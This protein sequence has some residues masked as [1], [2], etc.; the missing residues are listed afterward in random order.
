MTQTSTRRVASIDAIRALT[1][2]LMLFVNDI[3]G[4]KGVPHWLFHAAADEDM[5]G[6]SDT[7]F[8]AFLFCVGMSVPFAI[9]NRLRRGASQWSVLS[10]IL[11]RSFALVV[12]GLFTLNCEEGA[13]HIPYLTYSLLM[14]AGFFLIWTRYEDTPLAHRTA[15]VTALKAA[16]ALLLLGM[17]VWCD[18]QGKPFV[19]GWWGILGLIG[20]SYL[21][22]ALA[23]LLCRRTMKWVLVAAVLGI[24]LCVLNSSSLVPQSWFSRCLLLPFVPG[25][26]S[27]HAFCLSGL[28]ASMLMRHYKARGQHSRLILLFLGIGAVMLAAGWAAHHWWIVSKIQGTPTWLFFCLA[29]FFPLTAAA[30]WLTD[31]KGHTAWTAP[32]APAGTAT[33]TCY[34]L[35]YVWYPVC[36]VLGLHLPQGVYY[37][38][39][40]IL[41]SLAFSLIVIQVARGMKRIGL[42]VRL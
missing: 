3:P 12:M 6:F 37:G 7:I 4:L 13:G 20:W 36:G 10:H 39:T 18:V 17:V 30:Y 40:G 29:L 16:G 11:W 8:P 2:M 35:P 19:T 41:L 27:G 33:L 14:I 23:Y 31:I 26:W 1:M 34:L 5:L 21:V 24:V 38:V 9:D 22:T 25:G 32:I 28:A 42:V 15:V